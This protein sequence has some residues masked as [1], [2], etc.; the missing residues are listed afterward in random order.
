MEKLRVPAAPLITVD[1]YF[2]TWSC[3]DNLYDD[4]PRHWT[5]AQN[6]MTGVLII[7]GVARRFMGKVNS[8][9]ARYYTE[10]DVIEQQSL[11]VGPLTTRYRFE[12]EALALTLEFMTPL[13]LSD[14]SLMS[15][16]ISYISYQIENKDMAEHDI[17]LYFDFGAG[18][19]TNTE[20]DA[21]AFGK[22]GF[23]AYVTSGLHRMLS[24]FGDDLRID[25]GTLHVMAP[26]FESGVIALA[27]KKQRFYGGRRRPYK[28]LP[29]DTV[30]TPCELDPFLFVQKNYKLGSDDITGFIAVGYDDCK[31]IDYF[32]TQIEAYWRKG[33]QCFKDIAQKAIDDYDSIKLAAAAFEG[34]LTSKARK[35]S[36]K[37]CDIVS[38][39]YRQAVAA[40]KLTWA[41]G[42]I[43]FFSKENFS[44]GCIGTVDITYPSI[45]LFLIYNP[46]L[47]KGMLNPI[48][49]MVY[50]TNWP[51]PF[52]PH[53][54]GTYPLATGQ[55]YGY[56]KL[57]STK[58]DPLYK[59]MPVEECGNVL[60]CVAALCRAQKDYSYAKE[61][62]DIL[63]KWADYLES[64]GYDPAEQLCTDDFAGHLAHNTNLGVKSVVAL[65]AWAGCLKEL[66][67]A[68]LSE[69]YL[70]AAQKF[71]KQWQKAAFAGDHYALCFDKPE[72]FSIKY[73]MVW[74][75]LLNLNL[76]DKSVKDTEVSYY[77]TQFN[78]FG[79]PLDSRNDYTKSD[80]QMWAAC[81][82]DNELFTERV[83]DCMW[84]FLHHGRDRVPFTDWYYTSTP[85]MC[86]FQNRSVQGAL[87]I[88]LLEFEN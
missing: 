83:I 62:M 61:H 14:L 39:A 7:D 45:P 33:G 59:Q 73:N 23:S 36:D 49:K 38:L 53:D 55:V 4:T 28:Y 12:C 5:G 51:Y 1:P 10:P 43:Q 16:P 3:A 19:V 32:G 63:N 64:V 82:T 35:I 80:W 46:E 74:D 60:L 70:S 88:K 9:S 17:T 77:L 40:H 85:Y 84:Q 18:F 71:A 25:W 15:R 26:G 2:N 72:T 27:D 22:T 75:T 31:S 13:I 42:K 67:N 20:N 87:F 66:G 24:S 54:V 79:L 8:D 65:A 48:F 52:A 44:N 57:N 47:I 34:E 78:R 21:V 41:D 50:E 58:P 76:F 6:P 81:L 29:F 11:T 56:Q 86:T 68:R 30:T 37:Y 69:Q